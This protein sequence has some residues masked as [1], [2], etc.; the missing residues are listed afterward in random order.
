MI[1]VLIM[2]L[3]QVFNEKEWNNMKMFGFSKQIFVSAMFFG[4]NYRA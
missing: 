2:I 3:L 1:L 4:C